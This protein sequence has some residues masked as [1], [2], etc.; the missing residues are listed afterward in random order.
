MVATYGKW[1]FIPEILFVSDGVD[2]ARTQG[3]LNKMMIRWNNAPNIVDWE[4]RIIKRLPVTLP[5][6]FLRARGRISRN[7][8]YCQLLSGRLGLSRNE[9]LKYG[10]YFLKDPIGRLMNLAKYTPITWWMLA[11]CLQYREYNRK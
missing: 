7:L 9:A 3:W 8:T 6:G 2:V 11:K 5:L 1:G 10:M 4:K